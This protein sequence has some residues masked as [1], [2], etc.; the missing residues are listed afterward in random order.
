M[1]STSPLKTVKYAVIVDIC[2]GV[3]SS[4]VVH[5]AL[6]ATSGAEAKDDAHFIPKR[7][8]SRVASW[9]MVSPWPDSQMIC[10]MVHPAGCPNSSWQRMASSTIS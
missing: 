4:C 3:Y 6:P 7:L 1:H 5:P 9:L 10:A 2:P 8:W